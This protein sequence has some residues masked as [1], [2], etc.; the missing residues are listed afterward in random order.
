[1]R[2]NYIIAHTRNHTAHTQDWDLEERMG[3]GWGEKKQTE[4]TREEIQNDLKVID[5]GCSQLKNGQRAFFPFHLSRS[6]CVRASVCNLLEISCGG[7][8]Y[9]HVLLSRSNQA[10]KRNVHVDK[11]GLQKACTHIHSGGLQK[12]T[13]KL[14]SALSQSSFLLY[15]QPGQFSINVFYYICSEARLKIYV[16]PAS[17]LPAA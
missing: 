15:I 9:L 2:Q 11:T 1:M 10:Q 16:E 4:G 14:Q 7:W 12:H 13:A 17:W 3:G 5:T 6:H 8:N